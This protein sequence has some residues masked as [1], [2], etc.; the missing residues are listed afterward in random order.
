[1]SGVGAFKRLIDVIIELIRLDNLFMRFEEPSSMVRWDSPLF[2]I[3]WD[4]D[5]MNERTSGEAQGES[6]AELR[7]NTTLDDIWAAVTTGAKKGPTAAV[8]Q[9]S[10]QADLRGI[11][12]LSSL[13]MHCRFDVAGDKTTTRRIAGLDQD[14]IFPPLSSS[15]TPRYEPI[16]FSRFSPPDDQLD[17]ETEIKVI[18][19]KV[20]HSPPTASSLAERTS[21]PETAVRRDTETCARQRRYGGEGGNMDGRGDR[22]E[23]C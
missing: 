16:P 14:D 23:V 19:G 20:P 10:L 3:V 8:A 1:V 5:L 4:D 18:R 17:F 22:G 7:R 15:N 6:V 9:V 21:T 12:I 2:S 13:L 11:G